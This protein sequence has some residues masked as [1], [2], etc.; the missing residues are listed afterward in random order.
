MH[1]NFHSAYE[2]SIIFLSKS[3][4]LITIFISTGTCKFTECKLMWEEN[5]IVVSL[6]HILEPASRAR[7]AQLRCGV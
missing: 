3:A 1:L 4:A 6:A 7:T 2:C 5:Y